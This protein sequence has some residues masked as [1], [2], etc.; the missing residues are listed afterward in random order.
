METESEKTRTEESRT[1]NRLVG[2]LFDNTK[3]LFGTVPKEN[4]DNG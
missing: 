2:K 4:L 1:N 3:R